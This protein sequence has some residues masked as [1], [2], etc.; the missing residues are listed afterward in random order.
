[1]N[2]ET[3]YDLNLIVTFVNRS[4]YFVDSIL[5]GLNMIFD[6]QYIH[7]DTYIDDDSGN[8]IYSFC[9]PGGNEQ[10]VQVSPNL[11]LINDA[12]E[13]DSHV[14]EILR[15]INGGKQVSIDAH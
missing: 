5:I 9:E 3:N 8:I 6:V 11:Y 1:M 2:A 12:D 10:H 4:Q 14:N 13:F 7:Y 15:C